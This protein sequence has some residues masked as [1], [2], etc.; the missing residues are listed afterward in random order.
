MYMA[1]LRLKNSKISLQS[2][3]ST[4]AGASGY[5]GLLGR[6]LKF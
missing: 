4:I 1:R 3:A 6:N 5:A 2:I